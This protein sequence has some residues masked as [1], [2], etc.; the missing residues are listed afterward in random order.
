[1]L[2]AYL[3]GLDTVRDMVEDRDFGRFV[4]LI[5]FDEIVPALPMAKSAAEDFASA[6]LERFRNPFI[7]HE[8]LS[9]SLNS[10][11][12]WKVRVLPSVKSYIAS[13]GRA[14]ELLSFSL[15]ALMA[16]YK[17]DLRAGYALKDDPAVLEFFTEVWL[18]GKPDDTVKAV[19]S[20]VDFWGEDLSV[21]PGFEDAVRTAL[22]D[23]LKQG[24][25][26]AVRKRI[27]L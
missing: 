25:R 1:V 3:G 9:I 2:A 16:F 5:L 24:V 22:D 17:G 27:D 26:A 12:K 19:L 18:S 13:S 15:A 10:V 23:I 14:P 11:S 7:R 4:K 21:L 6:V 20:R 8:L